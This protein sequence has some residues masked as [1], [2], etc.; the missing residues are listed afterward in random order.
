MSSQ[1]KP[2]PAD[3]DLWSQMQK[4]QLWEA[5]VLSL[6]IDVAGHEVLIGKIFF[7]VSGQRGEDTEFLK[8]CRRR[9]QIAQA[10]MSFRGPLVPLALYS[11]ALDDPKTQVSL[12]EFGAWALSL[13]WDLPARFPRAVLPVQGP[14]KGTTTAGAV[15]WPWGAH[16]TK[17]LTELAAAARHWW[18]NFDPSDNTTAPT[19]QQVSDWLQKRGATARMADA[20]ATILR[21][22]GLPTGPRT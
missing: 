10:S 5:V 12:P 20:M 1:W 18:A 15:G 14:A 3:W 16:E 19:N 6:D 17:L 11:G 2:K 9:M 22:D 7:P 8:E 21:A 4:A 13:G